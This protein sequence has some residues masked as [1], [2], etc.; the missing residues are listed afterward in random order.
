MARTF[1]ICL[2]FVMIAIANVGCK[3]RVHMDEWHSKQTFLAVVDR[4]LMK[5]YW[6]HGRLPDGYSEIK[7]EVE[8]LRSTH[9]YEMP[10]GWTVRWKLEEAPGFD[11]EWP[12]LG[13]LSVDLINSVG[14][15]DTPGGR[16][17]HSFDVRGKTIGYVGFWTADGDY[18]LLDD[19]VNFAGAIAKAM[20]GEY[21]EYGNW[22]SLRRVAS[23]ADPWSGLLAKAEVEE[24]FW[25]QPAV[26]E[27][28]TLRVLVGRQQGE[29]R[30]L[31]R[32]KGRQEVVE[33]LTGNREQ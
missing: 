10:D 25:V 3:R 28:G 14:E 15:V 27:D 1:I 6:L 18:R 16:A 29:F 17:M 33:I 8:I 26:E 23:K 2:L 31:F 5:H 21:E 12:K 11:P 30:I 9:H 24:R 22:P 32:K 13:T 19:S 20:I 7:E 4:A